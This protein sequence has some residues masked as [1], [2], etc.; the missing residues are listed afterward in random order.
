MS[1]AKLEKI[2]GNIVE[3]D[4]YLIQTTGLSADNLKE[5]RTGKYSERAIKAA[6]K[7]YELTGDT[8]H[9]T[10]HIVQAMIYDNPR[11]RKNFSRVLGAMYGEEQKEYIGRYRIPYIEFL[12]SEAIGK[13]VSLTKEM[14]KW[15]RFKPSTYDWQRSVTLPTELKKYEIS[16]NMGII[17][18]DGFIYPDEKNQQHTLLLHGRKDDWHF[19]EDV[20]APRMEQMFNLP[21]KVE[22][23][24]Q[25]MEFLGKIRNYSDPECRIT[26][27]AVVT[28]LTEDIGI[29][30]ERRSI[31]PLLKC[32][33][34]KGLFEGLCA[35]KG[36]K[37]SNGRYAPRFIIF[38]SDKNFI[39]ECY[40]LARELGYN[41]NEPKIIISSHP[42][43]NH[44]LS[45]S[46]WQIGFRVKDIR[47]MNFLNPRHIA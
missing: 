31:A 30:R 23:H 45:H 3:T 27:K 42:E 5:I 40:N 22:A 26:S 16:Q 14:K 41:P 46:T 8:S 12:R 9:I 44:G 28:W 17:I 32:C 4:N 19:Y 7:I 18:G 1:Y 13:E 39:E 47:K 37:H 35:T 38:D 43:F 36:G 21:I 15:K 20:V 10:H 34:P 11:A 25:N 33:D 24:E 6:Q 2:A 29:S